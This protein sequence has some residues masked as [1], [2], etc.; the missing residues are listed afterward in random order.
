MGIDRNNDGIGEPV[1]THPKPSVPGGNSVTPLP[2]SDEF[3]MPSI[4]MQWQWQA[5]PKPEWAFPTAYG[6]LRMNAVR[7]P[8][9][10]LS[11]WD[12]PNLLLQKLPAEV[13]TATTRLKMY[14]KMNGDRAGLVMMGEDYA[15]LIIEYSDEKNGIVLSVCRDARTGGKEVEVKRIPVNHTEVFFRVEVKKGGVCHFSYSTNGVIFSSIGE[16]FTARAGRWIGAKVGIYAAQTAQTNDSG[17]ADFDW[18]RVE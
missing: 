16:P 8:E 3:N 11:L 6:F 14:P 10:S 1:I 5:N 18:F 13:F 2:V 4:G 12:V 15:Q 7:F 17:Y 9:G